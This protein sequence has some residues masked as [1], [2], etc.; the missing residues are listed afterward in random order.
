MTFLQTLTESAVWPYK[1]T[2]L[3]YIAVI[4]VIYVNRKKFDFQGIIALYRTKLGLSLMDKWAKK[5]RE[6]IKLVSLI[7]IGVGYTGLILSV[8]MVFVAAINMVREPTALDGSPIVLPGV[9][10]AGM[11]GVTFPL[12]TGI[13]SLFVI[14][15]VHEFSH[16]VVSR[17][18]NVKVK[19]S[20]IVFFGPILGAF[21][22]PDEKKLGKDNDVVAY[23]VFAAGPFSNV[24]LTIVIL[25]ISSFIFTPLADS[26]SQPSGVSFIVDEG[27]PA[28]LAGIT[29]DT[30]IREVDGQEVR[31]LTAFLE[32]LQDVRPEQKITMSSDTRDYE[33]TT[34]EHPQNSSRGYV[35]VK[36]SMFK[37]HNQRESKSDNPIFF[38]TYQFLDWLS[39]KFGLLWWIWFISINIAIINL[40]PI[41][42]TDGARMLLISAQKIYKDEDKAK[43]AWTRINKFCLLLLALLIFIPFLKLVFDSAIKA[44][45]L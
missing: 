27:M 21:V 10:I 32:V 34:T 38:I 17:A 23:S 11:E 15:V 14:I 25:L 9:P 2:I 5:Y 6:W 29:D 40:F 44:L 26:M 45:G 8:I 1:W 37:R 16:G 3:F 43:R 33:V 42:I 4:I 28:D 22:E 12:L 19:S 13:L 35:G 7:G 20:G 30:V 39:K 41:F 31:N 36:F 18:Y 24:L